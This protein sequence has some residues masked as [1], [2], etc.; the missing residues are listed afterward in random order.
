M[1]PFFVLCALRFLVYPIKRG[2]LPILDYLLFTDVSTL[3]LKK[4]I[5]TKTLKE[6]VK[7]NLN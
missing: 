5:A 4:L 6:N 1:Q 7:N 3:C 2:H